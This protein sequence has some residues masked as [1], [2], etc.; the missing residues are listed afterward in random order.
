VIAGLTGVHERLSDALKEIKSLRLS[1]DLSRP[2]VAGVAEATA[3][4]LKYF[5]LIELTPVYYAAIILNPNY[6]L[7]WFEDKWAAYDHRKWYK[8]AEKGMQ[9]F[10]DD[11]LESRRPQSPSPS[12]S[13]SPE[14]VEYNPDEEQP[15]YYAKFNRLSTKVLTKKRK[16][17]VKEDDYTRYVK[18]WDPSE[19]SEATDLISWWQHHQIEYPL[20]S[21]MAFDI[22]S[23]PGMSAEVE[24]IFSAAGRL[25]TDSRNGLTDD[26]I[27][28][29]EV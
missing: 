13:P 14:A 15:S 20:L 23:I 2:F 21:K 8:R 29:C 28:A 26:T 22:L 7:L 19:W 16:I 27:E 1:D 12:P 9:Q 3:K 5:K 24:R 6:R 10:W 18:Y 25:I 11:Y 4:T 17:A